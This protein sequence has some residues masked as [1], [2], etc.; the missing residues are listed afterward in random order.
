MKA[1]V[2]DLVRPLLARVGTAVATWLIVTFEFDGD[3]V[4]QFVAALIAAALIGVDLVLSWF[5]R[6]AEVRDFIGRAH[7][8]RPVGG[9]IFP[10]ED[11]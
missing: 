5:N 2:R 7:E 6:R 10:R 9:Y 1:L 8:E 4:N 11:E 3:L